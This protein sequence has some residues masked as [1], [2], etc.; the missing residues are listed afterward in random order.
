MLTTSNFISLGI[1]QGS[2]YIIVGVGIVLVL[3][4]AT[5]ILVIVIICELIS[6]LFHVY[7]ENKM[8]LLYNRSC[9]S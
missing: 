5:A 9:Q 1:N 8:F 7:T 4:T 3:A 6:F 2:V